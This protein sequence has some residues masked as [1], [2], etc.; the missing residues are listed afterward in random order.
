MNENEKIWFEE[1]KQMSDEE[2]MKKCEGEAYTVLTC[3]ARYIRCGKTGG[4]K[5]FYL[6][7][8]HSWGSAYCEWTHL[9]LELFKALEH[10]GAVSISGKVG[11]NYVEIYFNKR[12][13]L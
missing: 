9:K 6:Q 7:A 2:F 11:W 4:K 13:R 12:K 1:I 3:W 8:S 10:V 5:K